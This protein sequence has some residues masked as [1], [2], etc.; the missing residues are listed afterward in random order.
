MTSDFTR[1]TLCPG[2]DG[3]EIMSARVVA[4][5][6]S[7]HMHECYA[8]S[9]NYDGRGAFDCRGEVRDAAP[10]TCNLI[11]PGELHT[12]HATSPRGWIY[13]NLYVEPSLMSTL[14]AGV[15]WSGP[16]QPA[17]NAPLTRDPVLGRRL[18][19][20]FAALERPDFRLRP[21]SLLLSVVARIA[22]R[23]LSPPHAM[24]E[25]GREHAAVRRVKDWLH[26]HPE[27]NVSIGE[28]AALAGLSHYYLVR[29]FHRHVGVPPHRY[30]TNLRVN[31]ARSLLRAGV[32]IAEAAQRT[33]FC[34]QSHLHRCFKRLYGVT[35]GGYAAPDRPGS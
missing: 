14:L 11:A 34:D 16:P 28:L 15:E 10:G 8:V 5:S 21:E 12:G 23:H 33:G 32:P 24:R 25:P 17:F 19:R 18:A 13:R 26:H 2:L 30:Q 22:I 29:A 9:L 31:Q 3:L 27:A 35:P 20:V 7:K 4:H 6:F 1:F